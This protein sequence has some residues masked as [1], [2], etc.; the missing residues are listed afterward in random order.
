MSWMN[1]KSYATKNFRTDHL[2]SRQPY[3]LFAL[4]NFKYHSM[5]Y[6]LTWNN[7]EL[8]EGKI[9]TTSWRWQSLVFLVLAAEDQR[10]SFWRFHNSLRCYRCLYY[11]HCS[12]PSGSNSSPKAWRSEGCSSS[13]PPPLT[14]FPRFLVCVSSGEVVVPEMVDCSTPP[15][16]FPVWPMAPFENCRPN[17]F[18]DSIFAFKGKR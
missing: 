5:I 17:R 15:T 7:N 3:T 2:C 4:C 8:K 13:R 16:M 9:L 18:D 14:S 1:G 6:L 12:L 10:L 11:S